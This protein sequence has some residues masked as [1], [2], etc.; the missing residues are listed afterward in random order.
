MASEKQSAIIL[1]EK[2]LGVGEDKQAKI[3]RSI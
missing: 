1:E 3:K 2:T